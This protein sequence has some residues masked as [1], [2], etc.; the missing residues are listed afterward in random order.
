MAPTAYQSQAVVKGCAAA[1][2]GDMYAIVPTMW[3][4][5]EW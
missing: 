4:S 5:V 3:L 2:S 1:C